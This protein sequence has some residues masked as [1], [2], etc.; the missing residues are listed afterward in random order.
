M[1][2]IEEAVERITQ[3]IPK[4]KEVF[5]VIL[6]GSVARGD[7]SARHSDIDLLIVLEE[8]TAEKKIS[9]L[10]DE[11]ARKFRVKI[12]PEYQGK[13]IGQE[14]QTLLC[15]MFEEGTV[16][17]SKG[18]WLMDSNKLGLKAFR[19]YKFDTSGMNKSAKVMFS[20]ALHGRKGKGL[21]DGIT[22][23]DAGR[24]GLLVR[25]ENFKEIEM[26]F[27]RFKTPYK[28]AKTVYG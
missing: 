3:Q 2:P 18:I 24:G 9:K 28:I 23:I 27:A 15:K 17:Y 8:Q 25:K 1:N 21:I 13:E 14:D 4:Q 26:F 7:Y 16:L 6:Y 19:L 12:H 5:A 22:I 11:I 10:L 20:R